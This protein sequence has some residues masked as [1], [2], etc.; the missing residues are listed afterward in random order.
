MPAPARNQIKKDTKRCT[1]K[2]ATAESNHTVSLGGYIL[3]LNH[4]VAIAIFRWHIKISVFLSIG[5]YGSI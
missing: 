4:H 2:N 1:Y 5:N 3:P